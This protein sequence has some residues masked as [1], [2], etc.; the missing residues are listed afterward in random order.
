MKM[1]PFER[2]EC[3]RAFL[4]LVGQDGKIT[5]SERNL[6]LY[7]GKKLDFE[8]RFCEIAISEILENRYINKEPPEFSRKEFAE[9]VLRDALKIALADDKLHPKELQWL[10]SIAEKNGLASTLLDDI[11]AE[12]LQRGGATSPGDRLAIEEHL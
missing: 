3:L 2:S 9:S 10:A 4:L 1:T 7:I 8:H 11:T 6:L 12:L 5:S